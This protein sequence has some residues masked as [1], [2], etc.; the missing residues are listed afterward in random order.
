LGGRK[1][2]GWE[3]GGNLGRAGKKKKNNP[4]HFSEMREGWKK[5]GV[6]I[7]RLTGVE[8]GK[9]STYY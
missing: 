9:K 7:L 8:R 6:G 3:R 2:S 4:C 1:S 5:I